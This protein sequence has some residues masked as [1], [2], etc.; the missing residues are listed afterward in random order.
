VGTLIEPAA[1]VFDQ[2]FK[3]RHYGEYHRDDF[4][5]LNYDWCDRLIYK[6]RDTIRLLL[7]E[8]LLERTDVV[9][10]KW[11]LGIELPRGKG[12]GISYG[13]RLVNPEYREN[14][15]KVVLKDKH[16]CR[17]L[18]S[19]N[20]VKYPVQ[21]WLKKNLER[22]EAVMPEEEWLLGI[23]QGDRRRADIYRSKLK[24]VQD[25]LWLFNPDTF[26]R[27]IHNNLT[28]LK[29]ETRAF[30]RVDGDT[31]AEIDIKCSQWLFLALV[32][33][34][35]GIA[36][37]ERFLRICEHDLYEYIANMGG[38]SRERVKETLTKRCLFAPNGHR[39]QK[40]KI[41]KTL[42]REFPTIAA[43]IRRQK[44]GKPTVGNP[45]P[46]NK[47]A[48]TL[49]KE[50]CNFVVF[51]VC[52]RIRKERPELFVGTIHDSL[53]CRSQEVGYLQTVL[54]E[55]FARVGTTPR[56]EPKEKL[57]A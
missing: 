53:L 25:R 24:L 38:W 56:L 20:T 17:R 35:K 30:L 19:Y 1:L 23:A 36:D 5:N 45:K 7:N 14:Y 43:F 49:Q 12:T 34:K 10:D 40:T 28:A 3:F 15:H 8:R 46:W 2:L 41:K 4:I 26:S 16:I 47:L 48:R 9:T 18:D 13:Y 44:D 6:F 27:R 29:R 54:V 52:E 51:T 21:R 57:C 33:M 55:E 39:C 37:A 31:L 22:L 50:E 32:C 42:D 11:G